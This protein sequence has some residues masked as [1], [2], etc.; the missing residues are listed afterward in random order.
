[1]TSQMRFPE[2]SGL[3]LNWK[4]AECAFERES[5]VV[6]LRIGETEDL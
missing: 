4:V 3:G 2:V 6:L 5:G 1:M